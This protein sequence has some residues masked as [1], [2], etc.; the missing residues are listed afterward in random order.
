MTISADSN[1]QIVSLYE[2]S[3]GKL[4]I[5]ELHEAFDGEIRPAA[6]KI[7]LL[8]GS[9][10][11]RQKQKEQ[12]ELFT[13]DD[14]DLAVSVFRQL[15]MG[16]DAD[17]V[18]LRAAQKIFDVSTGRDVA[19]VAKSGT[20]NVTLI[21]QHMMEAEDAIK[22]ARGKVIEINPEHKHLQEMNR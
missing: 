22:R 2:S 7:A 13:K 4:S 16:A 12:D 5:E 18:R 15:A 14:R 9:K 11:Y 19:Q 3:D 21:S 20:F 1:T 8:Q 6:I 10:L 17:A